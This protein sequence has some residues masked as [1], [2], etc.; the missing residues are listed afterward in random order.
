[1]DPDIYQAM[2]V[3]CA[4]ENTTLAQLVKAMWLAYS[5]RK[6]DGKLPTAHTR[7]QTVRRR[8]AAS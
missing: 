5:Q 7:A 1:M 6:Y 8:K 3:E 2:R 4:V